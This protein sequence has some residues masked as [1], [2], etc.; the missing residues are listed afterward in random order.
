MPLRCVA[1]PRVRSCPGSSEPRLCS[2]S[3]EP[4]SAGSDKWCRM[5]SAP[6]PAVICGMFGRPL[7]ATASPLHRVADHTSWRLVHMT[8]PDAVR[9]RVPLAGDS[10]EAIGCA[11]FTARHSTGIL[12]IGRGCLCPTFRTSGWWDFRIFVR[13]QEQPGQPRKRC[14]ICHMASEPNCIETPSTVRAYGSLPNNSVALM[15]S[16]S[17]PT[18]SL[19][20]NIRQAGNSV[21]KPRKQQGFAWNAGRVRCSPKW[22]FWRMIFVHFGLR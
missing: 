4:R 12:L 3:S 11:S 8:A 22:S 20:C 18:S 2:A 6:D 7:Q 13:T 19:P 5:R 1:A 10:G 9:R 21:R 16:L 14:A 17:F 15:R